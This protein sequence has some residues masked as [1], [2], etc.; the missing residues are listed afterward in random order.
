M[1]F[2]EEEKRKKDESRER[3]SRDEQSRTSVGK[4]MC[5]QSQGK[6]HWIV[7]RRALRLLS[8]MLTKHGKRRSDSYCGP[9]RRVESETGYGNYVHNAQ[10]TFEEVKETLETG[11]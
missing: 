5:W 7:C 11:A 10:A 8:T 3:K 4:A 6:D 2:G 9:T 1:R